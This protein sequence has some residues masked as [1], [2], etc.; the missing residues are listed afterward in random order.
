MGRMLSS[1]H[2]NQMEHLHNGCDKCAICT[3]YYEDKR[4]TDRDGGDKVGFFCHILDGWCENK[5][6]IPLYVM[7]SV[8]AVRKDGSGGYD[9]WLQSRLKD[10]LQFCFIHHND[11]WRCIH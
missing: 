9:T 8:W 4:S 2:F 1:L 11:S 10:P 3:P 6:N 7:H 5:E